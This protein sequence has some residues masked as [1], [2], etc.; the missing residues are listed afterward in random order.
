MAQ[1]L[2]E[3]FRFLSGLDRRTQGW[4]LEAKK[5]P[6]DSEVCKCSHARTLHAGSSG[7][8][9]GEGCVCSRFEP[10]PAKRESLMG[11]GP[12]REQVDKEE[13]A[14]IAQTIIRQIVGRG[15]GFVNLED[16]LSR[17]MGKLFQWSK[18][19]TRKVEGDRVTVMCRFKGRGSKP[20]MFELD[21]TYNIGRDLYEV[22]ASF[23]PASGEVVKYQMD[24]IYFDQLSEPDTMFGGLIRK[25]KA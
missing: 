14:E 19:N 23:K 16:Y 17:E 3:E 15:F 24:D 2:L 4:H 11:R 5:K 25:L 1:T 7:A 6:Q 12:V 8:C 21:I 18:P 13:A 9:S 22:E 20:G 10:R